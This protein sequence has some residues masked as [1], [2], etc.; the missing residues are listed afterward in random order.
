[1]KKKFEFPFLETFSLNMNFPGERKNTE[2]GRF[3][4]IGP[5][6][7][8]EKSPGNEVVVRTVKFRPKTSQLE[9]SIYPENCLP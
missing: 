8:A 5:R 3:H 7:E 2:T 6:R 4:G 9:W 1:M